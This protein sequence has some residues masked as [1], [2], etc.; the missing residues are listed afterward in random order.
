[1]AIVGEATLVAGSVHPERMIKFMRG[2][3]WYNRA[4]N[5]FLVMYSGER[6]SRCWLWNLGATEVGLPTAIRASRRIR[7]H[8]EF[9]VLHAKMERSCVHACPCVHAWVRACARAR[10]CVVCVYVC[11]CVRVLLWTARNLRAE[12]VGGFT[13]NAIRSCGLGFKGFLS[14]LGR[15]LFL[16]ICF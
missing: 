4:M 6:V 13:F 8:L 14:W 16:H 11:M 3:Y 12:K 10:A 1:M 15:R 5:F 2:F 9:F 7:R